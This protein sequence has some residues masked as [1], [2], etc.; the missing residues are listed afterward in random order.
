MDCRTTPAVYFKTRQGFSQHDPIMTQ[1]QSVLSKIMTLFAAEETML[2]CNVLS[3]RIDAYFPKYKLA[4]EVDEQGHNNRDIDCEIGR[5][6]SIKSYLVVNSLVLIWSNKSLIFLLK[7]T[8][9]K[10]TL[11]NRLKN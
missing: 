9:S 10:I 8:E 3:Y 5:Q 6:K 2:Q 11:L 1:E 4:I 7:S